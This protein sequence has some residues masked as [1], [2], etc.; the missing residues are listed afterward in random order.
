MVFGGD[1]ALLGVGVAILPVGTESGG[2][3]NCSE[4]WSGG[5]VMC[6]SGVVVAGGVGSSIVVSPGCIKS[7]GK[8]ENL[9]PVGSLLAGLKKIEL[10][11]KLG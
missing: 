2:V 5:E 8:Y 3:G 9:R 7:G 6:C 10:D 11:L 4:R 1:S